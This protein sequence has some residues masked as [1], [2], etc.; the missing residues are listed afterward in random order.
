MGVN[1]I[2]PYPISQQT[3]PVSDDGDF[4][5]GDGTTARE[6]TKS[7]PSRIR[8]K[9]KYNFNEDENSDCNIND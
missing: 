9:V 5:P 1:I 4:C 8:G 2:A 6:P 3:V 7:R